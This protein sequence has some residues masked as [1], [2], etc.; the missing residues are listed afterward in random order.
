MSGIAYLRNGVR[1]GP[2]PT[3]FDIQPTVVR[4][5]PKMVEQRTPLIPKEYTRY[6]YRAPLI[7]S[8]AHQPHTR[9]VLGLKPHPF[10]IRTG[11][12]PGPMYQN[13]QQGY[14]LHHKKGL[15]HKLDG[16]DHTTGRL[17]VQADGLYAGL[18]NKIPLPR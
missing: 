11:Q 4:A 5:E 7:P 6:A 12:D 15:A 13:A 14:G 17:L 3:Y 2:Q 18:N 16:K 8:A 10:S 1:P 9:K